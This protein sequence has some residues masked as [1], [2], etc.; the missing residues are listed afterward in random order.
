MSD[1]I[2]TFPGIELLTVDPR[3]LLFLDKDEIGSGGYGS[4][5]TATSDGVHY[6]KNI[7]VKKIRHSSFEKGMFDYIKP[8]YQKFYKNRIDNLRREVKAQNMFSQ[9]NVSPRVFFADYDKMYY[10][11]EKMDKTLE[12]MFRENSFTPDKANKMIELFQRSF[13]TNYIHNDISTQNVMW[14]DSLNDFRLIDWGMFIKRKDVKDPR[15]RSI[16]HDGLIWQLQWI[17]KLL[18]DKDPRKWSDVHGRYLQFVRDN[19]F[20]DNKEKC[21]VF[22][23]KYADKQSDEVNARIKSNIEREYFDMLN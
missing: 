22:S 23:P 14:S 2:E 3:K 7:V 21:L 17:F 16:I 15:M 5:Y 9:K 1:L 11:M 13:S 20:Y 18:T 19:C 6:D 10:V 12:E 8:M 4:V